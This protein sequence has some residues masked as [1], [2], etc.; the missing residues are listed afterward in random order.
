M[1]KTAK[2]RPGQREFIGGLFSLF[3]YTFFRTGK[4]IHPKG[5]R[6]NRV[7]SR[8]Y[9]IKGQAFARS[10]PR[11]VSGRASGQAKMA[12][13]VSNPARTLT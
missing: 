12:Q 8:S 5:I 3:C 7:F 4:R 1:N 13:I 10:G 9:N 6:Y 11:L 2:G